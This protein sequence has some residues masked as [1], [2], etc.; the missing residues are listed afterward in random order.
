MKHEYSA[1]ILYHFNC[2]VCKN[3]WSYATTPTNV[4]MELGLPKDIDYY[5]PHCGAD[6]KAIIKE[7]FLDEKTNKI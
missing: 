2:G 7:G 6:E 5:C 4:M 1:E 3:W